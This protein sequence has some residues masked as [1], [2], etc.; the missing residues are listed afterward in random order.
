MQVKKKV[1]KKTNTTSVQADCFGIRMVKVL[2]H[3]EQ[4]LK[5]TEKK[6]MRKK[7]GFNALKIVK[8]G[9]APIWLS[10]YLAEKSGCV[11]VCVK[12]HDFALP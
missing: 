6:T 7:M 10:F 3:F 5:S 11:R 1:D 2:H 4:F 12:N 8:I 9:L